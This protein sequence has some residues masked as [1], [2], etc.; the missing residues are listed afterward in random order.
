MLLLLK[1]LQVQ[2][3]LAKSQEAPPVPAV[4][5]S[6]VQ[7]HSLVSFTTETAPTQGS[8]QGVLL[9]ALLTAP[10]LLEPRAM[11]MLHQTAPH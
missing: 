2:L 11:V 3:L 10:L 6:P 8:S 9:A 5:V 1:V 4:L 7:E